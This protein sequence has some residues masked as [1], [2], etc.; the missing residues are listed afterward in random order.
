MKRKNKRKENILDRILEV[1]REIVTNETKLTIAGF[2]QMLVENYKVIL[3]YQDIYI[4][5][6]TYTGIININGFDLKLGEMTEDD[7]MITGDIETI[8]YEKIENN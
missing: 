7:I 3:E 6:K 8:D 4:R 5:I 1:P 2:K